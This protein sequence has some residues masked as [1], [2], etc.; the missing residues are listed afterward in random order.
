MT[1]FLAVVVNIAVIFLHYTQSDHRKQAG[2]NR[3]EEDREREK[4]EER[5]IININPKS[6]GSKAIK[7]NN[8]TSN[9]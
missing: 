2:K 4:E 7:N 1:I 8:N 5:E 9:N 3:L 6:V